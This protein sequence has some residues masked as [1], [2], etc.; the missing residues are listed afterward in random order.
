MNGS[1]RGRGV[2]VALVVVAGLLIAGCAQEHGGNPLERAMV[3]DSL[4]D[5]TSVHPT[6]AAVAADPVPDTALAAPGGRTFWAA[7][8]TPAIEQ[9]PCTECHTP[10][11]EATGDDSHEDIAEAIA[12]PDRVDGSCDAC[13]APGDRSLLHGRDGV[14]YGL[15]EAYRLCAECH[16]EQARD[17]AA[18]AHGKRIGAWEGRRVVQSCTACHDPHDPAFEARI[19]EPGPRI[20]RT[21]NMAGIR[22]SGGSH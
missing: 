21:G 10:D 19:P 14:T 11:R 2:G 20:P 6:V 18:G 5:H 17:W 1:G 16:F 8:R 7:R 4:V 22:G 9:H 3:A 15:D 12:H 13:H